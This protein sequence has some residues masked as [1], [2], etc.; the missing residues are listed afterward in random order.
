MHKDQYTHNKRVASFFVAIQKS[1][2]KAIELAEKGEKLVRERSKTVRIADAE[3]WDTVRLFARKPLV[4]SD[5]EKKRLKEAREQA[6][7][8]RKSSTPVR[9]T[10]RGRSP[11][12]RERRSMSRS[13]SPAP[14]R[15]W[16]RER[17]FGDREDRTA[18]NFRRS[19]REDRQQSLV[20]FECGKP[21]HFR[22]YCTEIGRSG[23]RHGSVVANQA[24][25]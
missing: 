6:L 25:A 24:S 8:L 20:F 21:G 16:C 14:K 22:R 3:G 15:S 13:P 9:R 10:R 4:E 2:A 17:H 12:R 7:A 1:P 5:A 18:G 19:S 23:G 11:E